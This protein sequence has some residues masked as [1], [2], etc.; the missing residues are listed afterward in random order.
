MLGRVMENS[1]VIRNVVVLVVFTALVLGG[2]WYLTG[3]DPS[4]AATVEAKARPAS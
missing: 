1:Y 4:P 2:V 3:G